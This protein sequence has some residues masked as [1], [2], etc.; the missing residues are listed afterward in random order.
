MNVYAH[1][2]TVIPVTLSDGSVV[3]PLPTLVDS[4]STAVQAAVTSGTII[5]MPYD[6]AEFLL[7]LNRN[8]MSI[9]GRKVNGPTLLAVIAWNNAAILSAAVSTSAFIQARGVLNPTA[10]DRTFS[11]FH[12]FDQPTAAA[13]NL[14]LYDYAA[15]QLQGASVS[16]IGSLGSNITTGGMTSTGFAS[17]ASNQ[18]GHLAA[19]ADSLQLSIPLGTVKPTSGNLFLYVR[20]GF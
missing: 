1:S 9:T 14:A 8:G 12:T 20:E 19:M 4:F 10:K 5:L 11:I 2:Q 7:G 13:H 15:A 6:I 16:S 17:V 3:G 18:S